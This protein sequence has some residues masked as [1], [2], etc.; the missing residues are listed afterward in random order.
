MV[1]LIPAFEPDNKL[2]DLV[3]RLDHHRVVVVDDG[4]GSA[5]ANIFA[6][7]PALGADL[8]TLRENSGKGHALKVG[9]AYVGTHFPGQDVICAD[10]DGQHSPQ[11]IDVVASQV[12]STR[13]AMVLGARRFTGRVPAR[14]RFGNAMTRAA[15]TLATGQ[16]LLDT[17]TGL[18]GYPAR[19]LPWLGRIGGDRFEYELRLLLQ[20][21]QEGLTVEEVEIST[22]YLEDNA[23][24]HFR[25]LQDSVRVYRP[26]LAFTAS[27]LLAFTIDT[28]AL[29]V[30]AA[31]T[32]SVARSAMAARLISATVNYG[33]NRIW[34]FG[35]R[36]RPT[37]RRVSAPRYAA[38]AIGLFAAN[39]VILKLLTIVTGLLLLSKVITELMLFAVSY[40]VQKRFVFSVQPLALEN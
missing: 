1:V 17:Q 25:P 23:S 8:V 35:R 19:M 21:A 29:L 12:A 26:L 15:Y 31:L 33:V 28:L 4:S 34:V 22:I 37:S 27:S 18:R 5:Y 10:S 40:L 39:V 32:G 7:V 24:S 16:T 20:A 36:G 14:S 30:F 38:L 9:F 11:D 2:I 13:A 3:Q 6:Q